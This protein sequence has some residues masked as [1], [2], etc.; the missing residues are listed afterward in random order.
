MKLAFEK[1]MSIRLLS[2]VVKA[3]GKDKK[4]WS[5]EANKNAEA[6]T[7]S[8]LGAGCSIRPVDRAVAGK[9]IPDQNRSEDGEEAADKTEVT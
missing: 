4:S 2:I 7:V 5:P 1:K 6:F 9:Q 8:A 3:I